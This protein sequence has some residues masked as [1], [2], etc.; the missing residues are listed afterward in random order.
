MIS[1]TRSELAEI[2]KRTRFLLSGERTD[3]YAVI[4]YSVLVSLLSL[5]VP[6]TV[7][8]LVNSVAL[9]GLGQQ[10]VILTLIVIA[11]LSF[12]SLLNALLIY[13]VELLQRRLFIR[14]SLSLAER[15][16]RYTTH[17]TRNRYGPEFLNPFLEISSLHSTLWSILL[18]GIGLFFQVLVGLL[19]LAFYH[20]LLLAASMVLLAAIFIIFFVLGMGSIQSADE[21]CSAKYD[22]LI[23]LEDMARM[24][25]VF[26]TQQG[27]QY[28]VQKADEVTREW[29]RKRKTHFAI[30]FRQNI[31][32]FVMHAL[33][34]GLL[35]GLGGYLVIQNQ[36]TLGQLVAAEL[37]M[38][39]A[40][41]GLTKFGKYLSSV[42]DF[43]AS[44]GKVQKM[45]Q[46][47]LDDEWGDDI[48]PSS[49]PMEIEMKNVSL[50]ERAD[51]SCLMEG[52]NLKISPGESVAIYGPNGAGKSLIAYCLYGLIPC[53]AGSIRLDG[54]S[55][56]DIRRGSL[57]RDVVLIGEADFF[58]G[59]IEENLR[60]GREEVS[61]KRLREV[62]STVGLEEK[63]SSLPDELATLVGPGNTFFS[64]GEQVRFAL[65]RGLLK[66]PRLL[67]LDQSLDGIDDESLQAIISL[68]SSSDRRFTFILLTH[69]RSHLPFFSNVYGLSG[70]RIQNYSS[71]QT[72]ESGEPYVRN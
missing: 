62:L 16:P 66:E 11:V 55:V 30:V 19:L 44:A 42:Y 17:S 8:S 24:P 38:N 54:Y 28:G 20:P 7:Q 15:I 49:A 65:A 47:E 35:L 4:L 69:D 1:L 56:Q 25:L 6:V 58:H 53:S 37:V 61:L 3:L 32:S 41:T 34:S 29:L 39:S 40:L 27:L 36:L 72:T 71:H 64:K 33:G 50:G 12:S 31:A 10:L 9:G 5:V 18:G 59:T 68:L 21:E 45:L 57:R 43:V 48:P 26:R 2:L 60:L 46:V 23:W 70:G 13:T 14:L 52:V 22:V 51:G 63:V 67:I